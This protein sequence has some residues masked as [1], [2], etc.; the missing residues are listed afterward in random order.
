M[1]RVCLNLTLPSAL[2]KAMKSVPLPEGV[3]W[4]DVFQILVLAAVAD[5][6]DWSDEKLTLAVERHERGMVVK[7]WLKEVY[8]DF[9]ED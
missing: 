9:L 1:D 7:K 5:K 4:S 2:K 3:K 8:G 6:H